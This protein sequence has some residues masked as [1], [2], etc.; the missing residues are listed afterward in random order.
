MVYKASIYLYHFVFQDPQRGPA[1]GS[2]P[3]GRLTSLHNQARLG[4]AQV[5]GLP[6][7]PSGCWC[8][9]SHDVGVA[10]CLQTAA[11]KCRGH[12]FLRGIYHNNTSHALHHTE[13]TWAEPWPMCISDVGAGRESVVARA[14][15]GL[16]CTGVCSKQPF[17]VWR[18]LCT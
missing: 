18:G 6:T 4:V 12:N 14:K 5:Q 7:P 9:Q 15:G 16:N 10:S 13:C 17:S 1:R 2:W 8:G 3:D 11:P